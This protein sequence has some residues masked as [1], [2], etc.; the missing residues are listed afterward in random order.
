MTTEVSTNAA[1]DRPG[2]HHDPLSF[3]QGMG[4]LPFVLERLG[5]SS[6]RPGQDRV[7]I[8]VMSRRDTFVVLPTALGKCFGRG[9]P[10]LM[11]DG[12]VRAVEDVEVG[13]LL[14]GPDSQPRRVTDLV[15]GREELFE[16]TPKKRGTP[17][18][19]N[20][21]HTLSL[22]L[23]PS[24]KDENCYCA[25][26]PYRDR[27]IANVTVAEYLNSSKTFRHRA[28]AWKVG[29]NFPTPG[30]LHPDLPPYMLGLWLGDGR[31]NGTAISKPDEEIEQ[32]VKSYAFARGVKVRQEGSGSGVAWAVSAPNDPRGRKAGNNPLISALKSVGLYTRKFIPRPYLTASR[33]D[34]L[35]LLAGLLDTD[36]HLHLD[37]AV[38]EITFRD[39]A[40]IKDTV[41]LARSL[42]FR[43]DYSEKRV[44][45]PGW[46]A[47]KTY[48]RANISGD[49]EQIPC[50]IERKRYR[51]PRP[52][53]AWLSYGFSIRSLGEG[54]YYGFS[55]DGPDR[56]FLLG[57]FTVTHNSGCYIIPT[58]CN[59]WRAIIFSP[60]VALMQDQ[61]QKLWNW[62][63]PAGQVSGLQTDGENNYTLDEWA[64]GKLQFLLVA[65]ERL[66]NEKFQQAIHQVRPN[67][68]VLDEAHTL[69]QWSHSFRPSYVK[70]GDF[71]KNY[72]PDVVLCLTATSTEEIEADVRREV[73]IPD[74]DKIF[75]YPERSNLKLSSRPF[76]GLFDLL[77]T[78][79]RI[80]GKG[81]VYCSTIRNVEAVTDYL[82]AN[83]PGQ[84]SVLLYHGDLT[85]AN[86]TA[87]LQ[88]FM[89][90]RC[91][92]M[93]STNAFGMGIDC[94]DIRFVIH[95]DIPG[96]LE[97]YAQEAGRA[98]RDGKDSQC[99]LLFDEKSVGT[100]E[101][102]ID[103]AYPPRNIVGS[104]FQ[105]LR[106]SSDL[107]NVCRLTIKEISERTGH[108]AMLVSSAI[109]ALTANRVIDR[110]KVNAKL[111]KCRLLR[112]HPE[113]RM[114]EYLE[115]IP[116]IS[117]Q[118]E[119]GRYEGDLNTLVSMLNVSPQT[120]RN[121][122]KKL[123][124]EGYI[125]YE[126]PFAGQPTQIVGELEQVDFSL[127][128]EKA[129]YA[130]AKLR[131]VLKYVDTPDSKKH[132]FLNKYFADTSGT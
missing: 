34:R 7:V 31:L 21:S 98:G 5:F 69:S 63:I 81:V 19:V 6:L 2:R 51:G 22:K 40:L 49:L 39:E 107:N 37:Q 38:Y 74:A 25:G 90:G 23:T 67:L 89:E 92:V 41:F 55:V 96:T 50:R 129:K 43:A 70:I 93:V 30:P 114:A 42:G 120:V 35:E 102:F 13:D 8:N 111:F 53:H 132:G 105:C 109:V 26:R 127:L 14:M 24:G 75:Y 28:K 10:I 18:V 124:D 108:P 64:Q 113:A 106:E 46:D 110:P 115:A 86:K 29:V 76:L 65:P 112:Q 1:P 91:K 44:A 45:L 62:D 118:D 61:V 123:N 84:D 99:I 11:F 131:Y 116:R 101:F 33:E 36:G 94:P 27:E 88:R 68:V 32:A 103:G 130:R 85:P 73:G 3:S 128:E 77:Q 126:K 95:R 100:Q 12:S 9:T 57:D 71:V 117:R 72:G 121:N 17:L 97:A 80:D 20:K 122:L 56:L 119:K 58:L 87:N 125:E 78:V 52:T 82:A 47:P 83:L 66:N 48:Y 104:V 60:L 15:R 16:I 4:N 79:Q 54:D 59:N